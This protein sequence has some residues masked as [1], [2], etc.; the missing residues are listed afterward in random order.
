MGRGS[1]YRL[2]P[3]QPVRGITMRRTALRC[4][5]VHRFPGSGG[6]LPRFL[7][8]RAAQR[9]RDAVS[10]GHGRQLGWPAGVCYQ[11]SKLVMRVRFP[12]PALARI[13]R[14]AILSAQGSFKIRKPYG[15][16]VPVACPM[17]DAQSAAWRPSGTP[18]ER[19]RSP[20]RGHGRRAGRS[21]RLRVLLGQ[22]IEPCLHRRDGVNTD[23]RDNRVGME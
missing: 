4:T 1:S 16:G 3:V 17:A 7:P 19:Q 13:P 6:F 18:P 20:H 9:N 22:V 5:S 12:S 11:P 15:L 14:S 23:G 8:I 21:G 10:P 2:P